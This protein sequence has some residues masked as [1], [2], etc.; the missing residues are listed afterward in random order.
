M[1]TEAKVPLSG[2]LALRLF[3]INCSSLAEIATGR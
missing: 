3:V 2:V 1:R